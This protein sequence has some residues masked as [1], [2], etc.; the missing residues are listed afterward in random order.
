MQVELDREPPLKGK[1]VLLVKSMQ[2]WRS[3]LDTSPGISNVL[4]ETPLQHA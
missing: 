4:P 3:F 2:G 1:A